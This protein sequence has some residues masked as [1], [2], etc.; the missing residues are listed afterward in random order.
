MPRLTPSKRLR[1]QWTT[2]LD[3]HVVEIDVH[4]DSTRIA[5][6]GATGPISILDTVDGTAVSTITGHAGGTTTL[7]W[8]PGG[9]LLASGGLDGTLRLWDD[10]RELALHEGTGWT[11]AIVWRPDGQQIAWCTGRQVSL[12]TADGVL[13]WTSEPANGTVGD[14]TWSPQGE[15]LAAVAYGGIV[16]RSPEGPEPISEMP[17][18][19]SG[20][21]VEWSTNG[22]FLAAGD[23]DSCVYILFASS[24]RRLQMWGFERKVRELAWDASGRWLASGGG[25]EPTVWDTSGKN[26]PEGRS[27]ITLEGHSEVVRSLAW[28]P[29]GLLLAS[30]GDDGLVHLWAPKS[31][32]RPLAHHALADGGTIARWLPDGS[33]LVVGDAGGGIT[34]LRTL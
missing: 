14:L 29:T 4:A 11:N 20:L 26:G 22:R 15:R 33:G 30:T 18:T 13:L 21:T 8:R 31:S 27:P 24:G 12:A 16:M 28:S 1:P 5:T 2:G 6:V 19:G 17:W 23:Q 9:S 10:G 3:D 34:L 25:I 32:R 7:A